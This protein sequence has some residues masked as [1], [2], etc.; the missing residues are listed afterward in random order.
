MAEGPT[1]ED[2]LKHEKLVKAE[3]EKEQRVG[4]KSDFTQLFTE[5]SGGLEVFTKKIQVTYRRRRTYKRVYKG[6]ALILSIE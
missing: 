6:V 5:Y 3:Y 4:N 2:I 1:D